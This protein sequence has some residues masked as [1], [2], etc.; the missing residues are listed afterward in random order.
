MEWRQC[1]Q[2]MSSERL[3]LTIV[4]CSPQFS[5]AEVIS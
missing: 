2:T 3:S 5:H 1:W 4:W